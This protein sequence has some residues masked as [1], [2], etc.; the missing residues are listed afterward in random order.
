MIAVSKKGHMRPGYKG[1]KGQKTVQFIERASRII[2]QTLNVE[3][4]L[5][6]GLREH[7]EKLLRAYRTKGENHQGAKMPHP[8]L[9]RKLRRKKAKKSRKN[10][11]QSRSKKQKHSKREKQ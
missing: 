2:I 11:K 7:I 9:P 6:R 8:G 5:V 3:E 10:K 1:R 4:S